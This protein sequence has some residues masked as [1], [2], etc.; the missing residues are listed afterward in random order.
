MKRGI[1]TTEFWLTTAIVAPTVISAF[2]ELIKT[3]VAEYNKGDILAV[4]AV[5]AYGLYRLALKLKA[6]QTNT[7]NTTVISGPVDQVVA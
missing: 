7:Q 3:G 2:D 4:V 1:F 6:I 5:V